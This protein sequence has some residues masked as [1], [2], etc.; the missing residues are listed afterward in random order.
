MKILGYSIGFWAQLLAGCVR[1]PRAMV[2]AAH[3]EV[4]WQGWVKTN[5]REVL[6]SARRTLRETGAHEVV[7][8]RY[9][10][11]TQGN[12]A[13]ASSAPSPST[14]GTKTDRGPS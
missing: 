13:S 3:A 4:R 1:C 11:A 7:V 10:R 6:E 14:R 5:E 8:R 9:S 12:G 2:E